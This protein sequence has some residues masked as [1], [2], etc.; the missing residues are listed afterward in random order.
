MKKYFFK[1]SLLL[2]TGLL[3][4]NCVSLK[5]T[6]TET[7]TENKTVQTQQL[8]VFKVGQKFMDITIL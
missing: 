6:K 8:S 7:K 3:V 5:V 2:L 4:T 1:I